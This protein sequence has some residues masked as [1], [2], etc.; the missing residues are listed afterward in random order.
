MLEKSFI[1]IFLSNQIF[2]VVIFKEQEYVKLGSNEWQQK[3]YLNFLEHFT[4][5]LSNP[6]EFVCVIGSFGIWI[7]YQSKWNIRQQF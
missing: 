6:F 7:V 5:F 3:S 1:E 2:F 4:F